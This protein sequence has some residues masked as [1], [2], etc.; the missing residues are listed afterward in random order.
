ML[1]YSSIYFQKTQ[2]ASAL[3]IYKLHLTFEILL[4][5]FFD[6]IRGN[7]YGGCSASRRSKCASLEEVTPAVGFKYLV[8]GYFHGR[9]FIYREHHLQWNQRRPAWGVTL[10]TNRSRLPRKR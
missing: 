4:R 8:K 5:F 10:I 2:Y 6:G 9:W 7:P 3:D 1:H